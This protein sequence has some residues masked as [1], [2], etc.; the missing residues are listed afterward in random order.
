MDAENKFPAGRK[1]YNSRLGGLR[2]RSTEPKPKRK[3]ISG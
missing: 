3:G 1:D 2:A